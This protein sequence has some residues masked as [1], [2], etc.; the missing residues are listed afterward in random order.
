MIKNK[1]LLLL[2]LSGFLYANINAVVSILPQQAF[3]KAIG[4]DKVN[5]SLMVRPG[6]SPHTYEPKSSQMKAISQADIYFSIDVEFEKVWLNKFSNI[7]KNMKI[8]DISAGIEKI[9][10]QKHSHH[11]GEHDNEESKHN[12]HEDEHEHK[13]EI[14]KDPHVWLSPNNVKRIANN[15][16]QALIQMD[17]KNTKYYEQNYKEFIEKI[18]DTNNQIKDILSNTPKHSKFMVFHPAWG[19]FARDYNLEQLAI[20]VEGKKPKPKTITY[21]IEEAKEEDVK[22]I[23]TAPEFSDKVAKMIAN[24]LNIKVIK[25]SPL[26]P[27]WSENLIKLAKAIANK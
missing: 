7:N 15:I 26:N 2:S 22:A 25:I 17:R 4:G 9:D 11:H 16:Y 18:Y 24:E 8:V 13:E 1:I 20:E 3:L 10:M 12:E 23:F 14:S 19:Y 21:I 27:K 5:I 6:N